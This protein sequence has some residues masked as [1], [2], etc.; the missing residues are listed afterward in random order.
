MQVAEPG[1]SARGVH[2]QWRRS[3]L[4]GTHGARG[5]DVPWWRPCGRVALVGH[6]KWCGPAAVCGTIGRGGNW[7]N[8][9][10][11][12]AH[13]L[14]GEPSNERPSSA[15]SRQPAVR[16]FG[17]VRR[18]SKMRLLQHGA[19]LVPALQVT[20]GGPSLSLAACRFCAHSAW[21]SDM[22]VRKAVPNAERGAGLGGAGQ[23]QAGRLVCRAR[24]GVT[25]SAVMRLIT[26]WPRGNAQWTA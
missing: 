10:Q 14:R 12:Q 7:G 4:S 19:W 22:Q 11:E 15:E 1:S 17:R 24:P 9:A 6:V 18:R 21:V 20:A 3:G 23:Y 16:R 25:C 13:E 8:N 26:D 5:S 2:R